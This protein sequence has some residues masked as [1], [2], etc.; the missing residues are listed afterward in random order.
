MLYIVSE[1]A[2]NGEMFGRCRFVS[3]N[4]LCLRR[5]DAVTSQRDVTLGLISIMPSSLLT[6]L[7][8]S[9]ALTFDEQVNDRIQSN[10]AAKMCAKTRSTE[11]RL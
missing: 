4:S 3:I 2:Q 5:G 6:F 7:E 9:T 1:F 11:R 10:A 8:T